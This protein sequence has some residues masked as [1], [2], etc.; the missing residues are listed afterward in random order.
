MKNKIE[1][2]SMFRVRYV[3]Y[4][5]AFVLSMYIIKT[6]AQ[7]TFFEMIFHTSNLSTNLTKIHEQNVIHLSFYIS[8]ANF[9][10]DRSANRKVPPSGEVVPS[11]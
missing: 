3:L 7:D 5:T 6:E 8:C 1:T 10:Q 4:K 9:Y 11:T 2:N